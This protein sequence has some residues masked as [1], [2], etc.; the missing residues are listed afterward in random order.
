MEIENGINWQETWV[1]L[2]YW[3]THLITTKEV[4]LF[5]SGAVFVAY[6]A[7]ILYNWYIGHSIQTGSFIHKKIVYSIILK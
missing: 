7:L 6:I 2:K 5:L 1:K 3:F 4:V